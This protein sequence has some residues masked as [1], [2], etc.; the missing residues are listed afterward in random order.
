[1]KAI[2]EIINS[3]PKSEV[4][5]LTGLFG[6]AEKCKN[7]FALYYSQNIADKLYWVDEYSQIIEWMETNIV[8]GKNK[9]LLL[10]G[11][12]GIGKTV[13]ANKVI[14]EIIRNEKKTMQP[15]FDKINLRFFRM[16]NLS[17]DRENEDYFYKNI[18][19]IKFN[20]YI[21]DDVGTEQIG[22]NYGS[23]FEMFSNIVDELY[24][25]KKLSI[26]TT[27]LTL[28]QMGERYGLRTID[29]L[30]EM[31]KIVDFNKKYQSFRK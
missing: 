12:V 17:I 9:G 14:G 2:G 3:Q 28:P 15:G 11:G 31:C 16:Q 23:K 6:D 13:I 22:N 29:R 1:M 19:Q 30:N 8:N 18:V 7:K 4:L 24:N 26:I 21:L 20:M 27:N 25:M 5:D 10:S